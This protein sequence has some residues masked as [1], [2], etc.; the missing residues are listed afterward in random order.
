MPA[1]IGFCWLGGYC[2]PGWRPRRFYARGYQR[3]DLCTSLPRSRP[4]VPMAKPV[5]GREEVVVPAHT[6]IFNARGGGRRWLSRALVRVLAG[7]VVAPCCMC[8]P[9]ASCRVFFNRRRAGG[10]SRWRGPW[11]QFHPFFLCHP[12]SRLRHRR[13][14]S[15]PA[16]FARG[17]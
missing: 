4:S 17:A 3:F 7:F 11:I 8:P 14:F 2:R 5:L 10:S 13:T 16:A 9:A 15:G 12:A 6:F 1:R